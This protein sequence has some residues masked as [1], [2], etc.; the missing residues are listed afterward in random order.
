LMYKDFQKG[1]EQYGGPWGMDADFRLPL[2]M[3]AWDL[4]EEAPIFSDEERLQITHIFGQFVEDAVPHAA[5]AVKHRRTRHHHW[6]FAALGLLFSA[7]YFGKYYGVR[8]ADD[9]LYVADECFVPQCHSAR[10]HE[11][12]NGYQWLTLSHALTYAL[13]R[14]Y[15]AFFDE[16]HVRTICDLALVSLDNLGWQ[17]SYGDTNNIDGWGTEFPILAAAAWY[18]RDGRYA[19]T[20]QRTAYDPGFGIGVRGLGAYRAD[21][22]PVEP[23]ELTGVVWL[24]LD[25]T[26]YESFDG[27]T[28]L[29]WA[30]AYDKVAFRRDF[31]P[32]SEYLLLDGMAVGGHKH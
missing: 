22:E 24:P 2:L 20:L 10:S 19:W 32:Q 1:R 30:A 16:G 13:A 28:V 27:D 25:R 23:S 7:Q 17:A 4:V 29:P 8:E 18:Y 5:D 3:P 26:F 6:T 14:P 9:W 31:A 21:V 11:N 12:S 15:P